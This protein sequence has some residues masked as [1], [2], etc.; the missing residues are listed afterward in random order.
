MKELRGISAAPG[1]AVGKAFLYIDDEAPAIPRYGIRERDVEAEWSRLEEAVRAASGEVRELADRASREMGSE[2]AKIFEAHLLM[3]ADPELMEQLRERL[4]SQLRNIEWIVWDLSRE[5]YQK[6]SSAQ[7][8]YLRERAIDIHDV[9]RRLLD[10]LLHV[11]K[12]SLAELTEDVILV[13]HN[14]LPS[15]ALIMDKKR[16]KGIAMNMGG[17]TSHTAILARAF[18]IPA[19]LGLSDATREIRDGTRVVVDGSSGHVFIDPDNA[20][21]EHFKRLK[22]RIRKDAADLLSERDLPAQTLD[23]RRVALKANIEIP[24]EA[25]HALAN[26]AEGIGLYRSE[27]LFLSPG[28]TADEEGQ[29][30]AYRRVLDALPGKPVTIRTLDVGGDKIIPDLQGT[31]EKN[32]LLGW[33]AIRFCLAH[34]DLFKTQLRA[35][36]RASASGDLRIMFPMISGLEELEQALS[37]LEEAK[38]ECRQRGVPYGDDV[39]VGIMIEVPSAAMTADILAARSAFFSIGT[40][41]L[42]QYSIAT[43]RGNERVAYLA[44][45]FHPAV[46]RFIKATIDA[47]HSR[48]IPAAM[49]GELAGDP[50]A[51]AILLGLGLDEFSMSSS[52]IPSVKRVIR[53][54]SAADCARLAEDALK[55]RSYLEIEALVRAWL[56]ERFPSIKDEF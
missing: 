44:Q 43:D 39:A 28:Y 18:D 12:V 25:E 42:V 13:T 55:L 3:L 24:E 36:L 1:I 19:V 48:G 9:S 10:R 26:G 21:I 45:P 5:L 53:G 46:L 32:P 40:N 17:R 23:G 30:E 33:R 47:A 56:A 14:L 22:Q 31:E 11:K 35:L 4:R 7:D 27:F 41:D 6:M 51:T 38:A 52:S 8:P 54:T 20:T 2:H 16:V 29:Y 49:C 37:V 15:D 34:R 50:H